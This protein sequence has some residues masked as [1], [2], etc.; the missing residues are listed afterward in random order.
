MGLS[1]KQVSGDGGDGFDWSRRLLQDK[2]LLPMKRQ[3]HQQQQ[4]HQD[5]GQPMSSSE[6]VKCPRCGSPNTKFCYFN[7][8][9]KL[10]PRHFCKACKRHWTRGGTLRNVP[11]GGGRKNKRPR[12]KMPPSSTFTTSSTSA[13][14]GQV[15][16]QVDQQHPMELIRPPQSSLLLQPTFMNINDLDMMKNLFNTATADPVLQDLNDI[17]RWSSS[18]SP[19]EVSTWQHPILTGPATTPMNIGCHEPWSSGS[20]SLETVSSN[21]NWDEFDKLVSGNPSFP[22]D[23]PALHIKP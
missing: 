1:T 8:Y 22:W 11:E 23:D 21:W 18:S 10:Q 2:E 6:P 4:Q 16:N 13:A 20:S 5:R 17:Y 14:T 12:T 3:H 19:F 9:N 15:S 7:N